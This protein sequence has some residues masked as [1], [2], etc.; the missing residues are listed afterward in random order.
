MGQRRD[1]LNNRLAKQKKTRR[2]NAAR[3]AKE[4]DRK[5]ARVAAQATA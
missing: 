5:A 2:A 4:R 3:K 1:R